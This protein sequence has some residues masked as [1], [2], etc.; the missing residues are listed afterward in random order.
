MAR[1]IAIDYGTKRTGLAVTDPLGIIAS[2][3]TTVLSKDLVVFLKDYISKEEVSCFVIG[4]PKTLQNQDSENAIFVKQAIKLLTQQFP[5]HPI[6]T[7]DERFTSSMAMDAM[8][9]GGMK[10]KDRRVKGNVDKISAAIILQSFLEK[11]QS[12]RL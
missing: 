4:M 1:I 7:I 10:K 2:P 3:L 11:N 5:L 9:R 6:Y 8:L 12:R